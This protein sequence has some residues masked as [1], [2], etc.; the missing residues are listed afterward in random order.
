MAAWSQGTGHI[1]DLDFKFAKPRKNA[2]IKLLKLF[3]KHA[4]IIENMNVFVQLL[5]QN[6]P[7]ELAESP[8]T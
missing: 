3:D 8:G 6:I 7:N 4:T 2:E 1:Q 5:L